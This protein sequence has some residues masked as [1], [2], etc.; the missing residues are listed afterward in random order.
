MWVWNAT[1]WSQNFMWKNPHTFHLGVTEV[2]GPVS[3]EM[4]GTFTHQSK[5]KIYKQRNPPCHAS[6]TN[7]NEG[8]SFQL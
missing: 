6:F 5:Q 2:A 8:L 3:G 7:T 4:A 1:V